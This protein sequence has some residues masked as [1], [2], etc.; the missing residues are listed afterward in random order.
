MGK[1]ISVFNHKGGV[2]KTTLVHNVGVA[3]AQLGKNVLFIDADPQ[4]NL[5]AAYHGLSDSV[6]YTIGEDKNVDDAISQWEELIG[7]NVSIYDFLMNA[8]SVLPEE[9]KDININEK[10]EQSGSISLLNGSVQLASLEM[11]VSRAIDTRAPVL[12]GQVKNIQKS[13]YELSGKYDVVFI[14]TPPSAGSAITWVLIKS[15]DFLITPVSPTFFSLQA[16]DN[17]KPI[18]ESWNRKFDWLTG[19]EDKVKFVGAVVQMAKRYAGGSN[20][21]DFSKT[22]DNWIKTLN[23]R[24]APFQQWMYGTGRSINKDEFSNIFENET[25]FIME[26]CCDFTPQL[27]GIAERAGVPVINLTQELC[28]KDRLTS[29][30]V[31]INKDNGQYAISFNKISEQYKGPAK[32][33]SNML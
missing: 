29:N 9:K 33:L 26:V 2:G 13:L 21:S 30:A 16:V 23:K 24:I 17:L 8:M 27:R 31:D 22:T 20:K 18:F 19:F 15:S 11:D 14:D 6:E 4:M 1:I 5:T 25:P 32:N 3:L 7:S 10:K 28:T 12:G